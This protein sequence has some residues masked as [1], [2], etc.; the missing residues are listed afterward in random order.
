DLTL[1]RQIV[2]RR[3]AVLR[4]SVCRPASRHRSDGG[5]RYQQRPAVMNQVL[6][7]VRYDIE[8]RG[9]DRVF[10]ACFGLAALAPQDIVDLFLDGGKLAF[11]IDGAYPARKA[12]KRV[13]R[14]FPECR[15]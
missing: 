13:Q 4:R 8:G 2:R 12:V 10:I 15:L 1:A 7:A 5:P 3:V 9:I 14:A 6:Q 11:G